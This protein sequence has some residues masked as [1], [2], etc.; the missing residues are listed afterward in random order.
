MNFGAS[1]F[2]NT[3]TELISD[4]VEFESIGCTQSKQMLAVV[5]T[6]TNEGFDP[7]FV[8]LRRQLLL[9]AQRARLP[10]SVHHSWGSRVQAERRIVTRSGLS[11]PQLSGLDLQELLDALSIGRCNR[12]LFSDS[13]RGEPY[14]THVPTLGHP[15]QTDP[16]LS[17]PHENAR[18]PFCHS[19]APRQR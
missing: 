5:V 3:R 15:S 8:K 10:V 2:A 11:Y 4:P 16:W 19:G 6:Q 17:R 1:Q 18:R 9:E 7:S 13:L 12:G 14:E